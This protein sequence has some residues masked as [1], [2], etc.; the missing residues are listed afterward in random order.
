MNRHVGSSFAATMLTN[1]VCY[2]HKIK[3][4]RSRQIFE[5]YFVP[6]TSR[7]EEHRSKRCNPDAN[8]YNTHKCGTV[9]N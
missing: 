3:P 5:V 7:E 9:Q 8:T 1:D 6:L 4:D 2:I